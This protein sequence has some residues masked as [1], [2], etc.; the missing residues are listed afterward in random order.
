[1]LG[2]VSVFKI[3]PPSYRFQNRAWQA[4]YAIWGT[5]QS[6]TSLFLIAPYPFIFFRIDFYQ[7]NALIHLFYKLTFIST[8]FHYVTFQPSFQYYNWEL[9]FF[10]NFAPETSFSTSTIRLYTVWVNEACFL[11]KVRWEHVLLL[12]RDDVMS[13]FGEIVTPW[14][15]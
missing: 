5:L 7:A 2:M 8:L 13:Y 15:F 9:G 10:A 6:F 1:M 12:A 14:Q 3:F 11:R 4:C